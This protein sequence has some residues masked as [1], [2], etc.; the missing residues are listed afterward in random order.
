MMYEM[1][2]IIGLPIVRGVAGWLEN[3]LEDGKVSVFEYKKLACTVLKLG[4]PGFALYYGFALPAEFAV[5][6]PLIV[7]YGF[8]YLQKALKK[9][10]I[11]KK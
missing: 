2:T 5:S 4:V 1:L 9:A 11:K 3:A 6:I 7:D 10:N 8:S